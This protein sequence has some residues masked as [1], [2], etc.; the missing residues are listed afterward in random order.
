MTNININ[1]TYLG[2]TND[3]KPMQAARVEKSLDLYW[4][5]ECGTF[6]RK[7]IVF[8][9][10]Q[11]GRLPQIEKD[12]SYYS[13]RIDGYTKPKTL[14][15][16]E[17]MDT[18]S[19]LEVNKTLHDF[20]IYIIENGFLNIEKVNQFIKNEQIELQR[21]ED[22]EKQKEEEQ[23]Q[24]QEAENKQREAD[25]AERYRQYQEKHLKLGKAFIQRLGY[26]PIKQLLD[27]HV[28]SYIKLDEKEN[29]RTVSA[30]EIELFY[31]NWYD[32][33]TILIGDFGAT[34]HTIKRYVED[35][36]EGRFRKR[37]FRNV[38]LF[39]EQQLLSL[40]YGNIG[41]GVHVNTINTNMKAIF[42]SGSLPEAESN[43]V[44]LSDIT[45]PEEEKPFQPEKIEFTEQ[46]ITDNKI[47]ISAPGTSFCNF[48]RD[49]FP[50][51]A[52]LEK[53]VKVLRKQL[54]DTGAKLIK[55][56]TL[57]ILKEQKTLYNESV[58]EYNSTFDQLCINWR[59][60]LEQGL[61][62]GYGDDEF[63]IN[64]LRPLN[65]KLQR[66]YRRDNI[67]FIVKEVQRNVKEIE[68]ELKYGTE[69]IKIAI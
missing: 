59:K 44:T 24:I 14:Y 11:E 23:K 2:F 13:A 63:M 3:K 37:N 16:L 46:V 22:E 1:N 42:N 35:Y 12:Y 26:D 56:N 48:T 36:K 55:S 31:N 17:D 9:L 50:N 32:K 51:I 41:M 60:K 10:L 68:Q 33:M 57:K 58:E 15:K 40:I 8:D 21:I 66:M 30:D 25:R 38:S 54:R 67:L 62:T 4:R 53:D 43:T 64:V 7:Q 47:I 65:F 18:G 49:I 20:A 6:S 39:L 61:Y 27:E 5:L 19:Y 69:Y 28:P 45:V 29:D 34:N 52:Q